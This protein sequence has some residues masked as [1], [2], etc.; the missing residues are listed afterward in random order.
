M[1]SVIVI[2][3]W[4]LSGF[5]AIPQA[6]EE[7]E[8]GVHPSKVGPAIIVSILMGIVFYVIVI[9]DVAMTM[10]WQESYAFELPAAAMFRIAFGYECAAQLV[11][12]TGMLGLITTLNGFFIASSRLLFALGRG[13]L[14][15]EWFGQV[16]PRFHTPRNALL[17][18][19]A[20]ALIGPFLGQAALAPIVNSSPAYS[21]HIDHRFRG[22]PSTDS[23]GCRP[24]IPDDC[25]HPGEP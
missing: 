20:T 18:V 8:T 2:V 13:G 4:F 1:I 19:G 23:A 11:L 14:L 17:F 22:K 12:F 16:H 5:D 6:A 21:T 24:P 10:P 3:P 7:S 25:V 9:F 15:P